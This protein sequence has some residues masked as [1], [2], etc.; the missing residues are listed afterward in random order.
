M[1]LVVV[2]SLLGNGGTS[3]ALVS[4]RK[5]ST[6]LVLPENNAEMRDQGAILSYSLM[7][8]HGSSFTVVQSGTDANINLSTPLSVPSSAGT[9]KW[10]YG[11]GVNGANEIFESVNSMADFSWSGTTAA[12]MFQKSTGIKVDDVVALDVPAMAALVKVTGP[13]S[14]PGIPE[15]LTAENFSTVVLHDLY[16]E[17]R[18]ARKYR[19]K[20]NSTQSRRH[21]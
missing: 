1:V 16:A 13:L 10:F 7:H 19:G 12:A 9:R 8:I 6:A 14:I 2:K 15:Q 3:T 17:Y 4:A 21:C 5:S 11:H 18:S 20:R